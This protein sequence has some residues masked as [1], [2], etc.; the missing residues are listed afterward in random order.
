MKLTFLLIISLALNIKSFSQ[1]KTLATINIS[2]SGNAEFKNNVVE[3]PWALVQNKI[4][5]ID[6]ARLILLDAI[7]KQQI[8]FQFEKKGTEL[9]QNL[10]VQI[11]INS[12]QSKN[13]I[14]SYGKRLA[15][16]PKTYG[17]YIPERK[18]DFA[19]ENDKIAFRMYGKA[20]ELTPKEM[21]Y[22]MDVWV[23]R[24]DKLILNER[25]KRGEYHIDH[26][27]GMDYYHVGRSLGAG[28]IM[29]F[30]NDSICYS[31]NYTDY[32]V[33]DN[34][35]LRTTFQLIYDEW[36]IGNIKLKA[37]KTISLDAGSQMNKISVQ[38]FTADLETI[39]LAAGI[40]TRKELGVKY[41]DEQSGIMSFWEPT[42]GEDGTTAVACIFQSPVTRMI[43]INGQLLA[44]INTDKNKQITYYAGACWDKA[45][46]FLNA[47]S[48]NLYLENFK[49]SLDHPVL[50]KVQ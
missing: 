2:N 27:D 43:E 7:S 8:P 35:P 46:D 10:L 20:L 15:F 45:G 36:Q 32:K 16:L 3:I 40:V 34:G 47:K 13:I 14:L 5:N 12:N 28:R 44:K 23:K 37:T 50:V 25:Y 49:S 24:T 42:H 31:R 22:G 6:T 29:P 39:P 33:L 1:N 4:A 17:R 48:W 9:I 11:S 19:W 26:G 41:L 30:L 38:Y 21:G 18:D